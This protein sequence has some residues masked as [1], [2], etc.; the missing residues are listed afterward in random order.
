MVRHGTCSYQLLALFWVLRP[1][2]VAAWRHY[3]EPLSM[4]IPR[5]DGVY[6]FNLVLEHRLTMSRSLAGDRVGILDYD[7]HSETW[8]ERDSDVH[9]ACTANYSILSKHDSTLKTLEMLDDVIQH[10]GKHVNLVTINGE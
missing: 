10:D 7:P 4:A 6:E 5:H 8:T 1:A 9:T 2:G 3:A